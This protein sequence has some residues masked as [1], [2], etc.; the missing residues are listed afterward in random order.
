L[1]WMLN[2]GRGRELS[3]IRTIVMLACPNGGS[4]YLESV[5]RGLGLSLD[6]PTK[7]SSLPALK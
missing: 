3:R 1:E 7:A 5:R 2:Q 4:E 6:P